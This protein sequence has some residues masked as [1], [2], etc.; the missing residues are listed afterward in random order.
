MLANSTVLS[1]STVLAYSTGIAKSNVVFKSMFL[2]NIQN[3]PFQIVA[4]DCWM[5]HSGTPTLR[6]S[7]TFCI[8]VS[9]ALP[10]NTTGPL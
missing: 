7:G 10:P 4:M 6:H 1:C 5:C 2:S 8:V 9:L 3:I